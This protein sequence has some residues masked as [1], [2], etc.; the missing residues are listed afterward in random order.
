MSLER[1]SW[2]QK[3]LINPHCRLCKEVTDRKEGFSVST[4][5]NSMFTFGVLIGL[6]FK[7]YVDLRVY[8]STN[9]EDLSWY[10][11]SV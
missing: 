6:Y 2:R 9:T 3:A 1:P 8:W 5:T 11:L 10:Q 7:Y 4:G